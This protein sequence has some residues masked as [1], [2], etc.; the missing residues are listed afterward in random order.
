[1]PPHSLMPCSLSLESCR[2]C[3]AGEVGD[4]A[5]RYLQNLLPRHADVEVKVHERHEM[6]SAVTPVTG[7]AFAIVHQAVQ[8]TLA[9]DRVRVQFKASCAA[10]SPAGRVAV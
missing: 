10:E 4:F 2:A 6:A 8:E 7:S 1:M 9:K 3:F 5:E